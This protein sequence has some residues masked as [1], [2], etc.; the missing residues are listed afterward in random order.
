MILKT[1][2]R[3]MIEK[4]NLFSEKINKIA[5]NS[6]DGKTMQPLDSIERYVYGKRKD[7]VSEIEEI[8]CDNIY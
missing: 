2:Q 5:L 8:K 3:F 6:N 1:H 7:L 4:N